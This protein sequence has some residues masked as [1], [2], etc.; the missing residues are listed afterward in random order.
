M[1][2]S[3]SFRGPGSEAGQALE[4]PD[5]QAAPEAGGRSPQLLLGQADRREHGLKGDP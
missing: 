2:F 3:S 5:P 1:P 4:P